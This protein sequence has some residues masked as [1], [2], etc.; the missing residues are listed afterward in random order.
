VIRGSPGELLSS[1]GAGTSLLTES[2]A[3]LEADPRE[4]QVAEGRVLEFEDRG[5]RQ[6]W[7][8]EHA[9]TGYW[10]IADALDGDWTAS[11]DGLP[12]PLIRADLMHRAIWVPPGRHEI[13][14]AHR[15]VVALSLFGLS[16]AVLA[17]LGFVALSSRV[18]R[19]RHAV[20]T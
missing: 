1:L 6:R 4:H 19:S 12:A 18:L 7:V 17:A 5:A 11:I 3:A 8:V 15:P 2:V 10:V 16:L 20:P 14:L 13:R 9:A